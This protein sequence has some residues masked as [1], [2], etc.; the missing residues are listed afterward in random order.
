M[1]FFNHILG[2]TKDGKITMVMV[3]YSGLPK[4][5]YNY[6]CNMVL[7][8]DTKTLTF[9]A[10][11]NK[12][13]PEITLPLSKVTFAGNKTIEEIGQ[14]KTKGAIIGGILFGAAGAVIGAMTAD[15]RK[16]LKTLYIINYQAD[17]EIKEIVLR[18]NGNLNFSKFQKELSEYLPKQTEA[19]PY[20]NKDNITL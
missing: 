18:E 15:E 13:A 8:H 14:S 6:P 20:E 16:K 12:K 5:L 4:F 7:D 2:K 1:G 10:I 11:A 3:H 9:K 19:D 17:E